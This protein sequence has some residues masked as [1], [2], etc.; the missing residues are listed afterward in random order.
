MLFHLKN[1]VE[2]LMSLYK[3]LNVSAE[4]CCFLG[5]LPFNA[6]FKDYVHLLSY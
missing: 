3:R 6:I 2:Y 1:F 5:W 4:E